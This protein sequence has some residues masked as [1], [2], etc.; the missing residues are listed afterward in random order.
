MHYEL[1]KH[2]CPPNQLTSLEIESE[3]HNIDATNIMKAKVERS[4]FYLSILVIVQIKL[5]RK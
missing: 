2:I 3:I 5:R 4:F 1:N